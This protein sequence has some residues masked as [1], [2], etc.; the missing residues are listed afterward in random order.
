MVFART[1]KA[2][3]IRRLLKTERMSV[4]EIATEVNTSP[5]VVRAV[6]QRMGRQADV[7]H[8]E[9]RV[10]WLEMQLSVLREQNRAMLSSNRFSS[11]G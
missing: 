10:S 8:L 6:R 11:A 4:A 9:S 2:E 3:E 7:A 1:S 5:R